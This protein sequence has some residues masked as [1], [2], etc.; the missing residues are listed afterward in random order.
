MARDAF[1][2]KF[3]IL[4]KIYFVVSKHNTIKTTQISNHY[5][6]S[7]HAKTVYVRH[8]FYIHLP[9]V[10]NFS[11]SIILSVMLGFVICGFSIYTGF[12]S[13]KYTVEGVVVEG[14]YLILSQ[15]ALKFSKKTLELRRLTWAPARC[16]YSWERY[17]FVIRDSFVQSYCLFHLIR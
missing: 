4:C 1:L 12:E 8:I 5:N 15:L 16:G 13:S 6:N 9:L 2:R 7:L 3:M 11:M 10:A 14:I 17:Y